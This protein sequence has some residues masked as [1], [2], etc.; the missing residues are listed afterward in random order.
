MI[1]PREVVVHI[2][3]RSDESICNVYMRATLV[4]YGQRIHTDPVFFVFLVLIVFVTDFGFD[5][6]ETARAHTLMTM[7]A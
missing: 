1:S 4:L 5:I 7:L 2:V 3:S 6:E